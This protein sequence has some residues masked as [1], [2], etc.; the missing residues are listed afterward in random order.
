MTIIIPRD[1]VNYN[2]PATRH[3]LRDG[4]WRVDANGNIVSPPPPPPG[5]VRT[6]PP[7]PTIADM[8]GMLSDSRFEEE[9]NNLFSTDADQTNGREKYN[10]LRDRIKNGVGDADTVLAP[11][12]VGIVLRVYWDDLKKSGKLLTMADIEAAL[13]NPTLPA[14]LRSALT[15]L[16]NNPSVFQMY[17]G[18]NRNGKVDGKISFNDLGRVTKAMF[19]EMQDGS[20]WLE[21]KQKT[22][23]ITKEQEWLDKMLALL[24]MNRQV[25]DVASGGKDDDRFG[26]GDLKSL[27]GNPD[28]APQLKSAAQLFS[29]SDWLFSKIDTGT[30]Q[31]NWMD[32]ADGIVGTK[33]LKMAGAGKDFSY[34]EF[35]QALLMDVVKRGIDD[36]NLDPAIKANLQKFWLGT[37][38]ATLLKTGPGKLGGNMD[39]ILKDKQLNE[40]AQ[41]LIAEALKDPDT[42]AWINEQLKGALNSVAPEGSTARESLWKLAF[43]ALTGDVG[44]SGEAFAEKL[45]KEI[46]PDG[47]KKDAIEV[48]K[49]YSERI[50]GLKDLA[51]ETHREEFKEFSDDATGVINDY[52]AKKAAG[53]PGFQ[54]A[55]DFMI[56]QMAESLSQTTGVSKENIV[57]I[58][59]MS[60]DMF[61]ILEK[62]PGAIAK[63]FDAFMKLVENKLIETGDWKK[64]VDGKKEVFDESKFRQ[65]MID[66][67]KKGYFHAAHAVYNGAALVA[68]LWKG[69]S[70]PA[71]KAQLAAIVMSTTSN[72]LE[73][74]YKNGNYKKVWT[75][76]LEAKWI[77]P[78]EKA[79]KQKVD[80]WSDAPGQ[81]RA[82]WEEYFDPMKKQQ[83]ADAN[84]K[85]KLIAELTPDLFFKLLSVPADMVST[86]LSSIS[87]DKAF[88]SGDT[89]KGAMD[90]GAAATG[91][92]STVGGFMELAGVGLRAFALFGS[93]G[94]T[95]GMWLGVVGAYA[96]VVGTV[97][98]LG[99]LLGQV[100]LEGIRRG[101]LG[102]DWY[103][104]ADRAF[105]GNPRYQELKDKVI[106]GGY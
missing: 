67:Y 56:E 44:G 71:E 39:A 105:A 22:P 42:Q 34:L 79:Y 31:F 64:L 87:A 50:A 24:I 63:N 97:L 70:T 92:I 73:A 49:A 43:D 82:D 20:K 78:I 76:D 28:L 11:L 81:I 23:G 102:D 55:L 59:K 90:T 7:A 25:V 58:F 60:I 96:G 33:T 30:N 86:V 93:W 9:L 17:D 84:A 91:A 46:D 6:E 47:T 99:F 12:Q 14:D 100:A 38:Q 106:S 4:T 37:E 66:W 103:E 104:D 36:P 61:K 68:R 26:R 48:V 45:I 40:E 72:I 95:S 35:Q 18:G 3:Y 21:G 62:G 80:Y 69:V 19:K 89:W 98:G 41:K 1:Q 101:R 32:D 75:K 85:I 51:G 53:D 27:A 15:Y 16:K 94:A 74:I 8:F 88:K 52:A 65:N 77:D 10:E 2:D 57:E 29:S 13:K 54:E 5:S 83:L